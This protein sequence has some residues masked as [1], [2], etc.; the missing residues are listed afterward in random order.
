MLA[1]H[2]V[3]PKLV[4][5]FSQLMK[6]WDY[7]IASFGK[8]QPLHNAHLVVLYQ[9]GHMV[10]CITNYQ[11]SQPLPIIVHTNLNFLQIMD[12]YR[13]VWPCQL[14]NFANLHHSIV[15]GNAQMYLVLYQ[16]ILKHLVKLNL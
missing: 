8:V 3:E 10:L 16:L 14:E 15:I 12:L 4:V 9:T 5:S 1:I 11:I 6:I 13:N 2:I 7:T